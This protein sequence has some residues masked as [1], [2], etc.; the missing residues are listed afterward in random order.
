M[1]EIEVKN[2][3]FVYKCLPPG[4][5]AGSLRVCRRLLMM[6]ITFDITLGEIM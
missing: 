3:N 6:T 4:T 1:F 2:L 5:A